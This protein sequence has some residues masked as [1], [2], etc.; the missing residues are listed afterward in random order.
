LVLGLETD[1]K[2]KIKHLVVYGDVELIVK[3]IKQIYQEKHPRMRAYKNCVW[4]LIENFFLSFN[5]HAIPEFI[6]NKQIPWLLQLVL[7]DH[8]M[9]QV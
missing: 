5:I 1:R 4:D 6:I 2:L 8:Q 3:Q 7:L 9:S